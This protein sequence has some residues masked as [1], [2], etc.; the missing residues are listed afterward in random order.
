MRWGWGLSL[1]LLAFALLLAF[2]PLLKGAV[3]GGLPLLGFRGEV[4]EVRG[5]LLLGLRLKGVRLEGQ[6]LALEAEE[7][8]LAYDLLGLFRRELPLSL[9]LRKAVVRPTW[10]ALVPEGGGPPPAFRLLFRSL[11]LEDVAV[12]L[13]RGER[14]FLPPLRLTLLGENP[15]RFLARLPGGSFQGEAKALSPDLAAW[16]VGFAG[17]VRGLSFFY[18]GL[19]GG[20]LSGALRLGPQGVFGEAEVREGAVEVGG[21]LLTAIQGEIV[22]KEGRVEARLRGRGLE[23]PVAATAEVDLGAPRYRFLVEGRPSLRALAL[24]YGLALPVEGD[25]RLVLE[26]EGWEA[27]RLQGAFQ[28]E[29]RLLG[30]P[31]RH[32]GTLSFREVFALEARVE[33]R[34]FDRT[35]ILEAGLEGGRYRARYRDSLGSALALFGEGERYEGE[36][37]AAWPRPLEGLAAVRF[38]GEGS[39][40]RVVVEGP[41]ARLPLFPPLDL[42]GEVVGEGERVSG[43]VGPL[44]FSGTWDDLALRLRPTPLLVGQVEGEGRLEGGRLLADL[45]YTSPYAAFPVRVRQG[46]GAFFLESPYGEGSYRG[47]VFAL[48]LE[49]LP[50]RLLEEARLYGEAVYREGALSGALRLEGRALEARARLRGLGADLEGRLSTPLGSLPL[51]GAYDL[52]EGLRLR[53]GGL[54]LTYREALRLVGEA[55][56]GGFRLRADLAYG[57]GF[58]GWASLEGPLGLRG[59]LWGEGGRLLLALSG[60][61]EG[62]GEVYPGLLLSGRIHPPWPEGLATPPLAF[63]LTREALE[64]AGAG[65]VELSGRYPFLLD[66]PF[67]YRGVEGRL[68]AQGDLEGG[69]VA[70]STPF[71]AL[72]GAGAWRAL[73][74]EGSG[75]LPALG[76]W[77]LKGEA[78][79]FALAYRGEAA[80]PRAGLVLELSG[81]GK[82]LRFRGEA[83]GLVLAGGYG[84]GLALSL[85]ARGYD[86]AP[87]GLPARLWGEW[88]LEGGRLRVETP[89]GQAVLEG[90]ALLRARLFLEGPYLE[91]KGRSFRRGFPCAFPAATGRA[92][93]PWRGRGRGRPLGALRFRLA[94][95]AR[96]PYLEPL[97]FRGEVEVADG[98]RYRLQGPLALEG[99]G[100]GYRGSFRL[101][102]AFLGKAGEVRGSFRGEGLRLEGAGEGVY[103]ELPFAFRGGLGKGFSSRSA[104]P[105]GR[106]PWRR[107]RCAS[108]LPRWPPWPRPSASPSPGRR[109]EGSPSRGRARGRPGFASLGSPSW[110]ATGARPSPS[111]SRDG[112]RGFPGTGGEGTLRASWGFPGRGG[113]AWGRRFRG[114]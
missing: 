56:L 59:R 33:G 76:P 15:Y 71:G 58:S 92:G 8:D 29:G 34:L 70:L 110:P 100:A 84:E 20:R 93:W 67:R 13:P 52:E 31:F 61:V 86:L 27:L 4:R 48:R 106:W 19:K 5:H 113:S 30:E 57:E 54:R 78:D 14:L 99:E 3:E 104:T 46:E 35:Y 60:P 65:R 114:G 42:S 105:G 95:E 10:E 22:L 91:G 16:E 32:Q 68:W 28:G 40:Y 88:G 64:L 82:A 44:T 25:G 101:P 98:V 75:D 94:G 36:G 89:Y 83:P 37:R 38:R 1:G 66:L 9:S 49:G 17:E 26:G 73:A 80:F 12:E 87:F 63:R 47:G 45:R 69:S 43:R 23:G 77:T 81:K 102:F 107:G 74:L 97:P 53:A 112:R 72:R 50:L 109:G 51:S 96:V 103:G 21:F 85:A 18:E 11:R 41:G 7:V 2:P 62:E 90:T 55:A 39:R 24:H 108:P 6:G 111:S 79:L